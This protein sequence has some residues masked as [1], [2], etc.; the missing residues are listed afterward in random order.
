M[1][2]GEKGALVAYLDHSAHPFRLAV[3]VLVVGFA[4]VCS[5]VVIPLFFIH[6]SENFL[7]QLDRVTERVALLSGFYIF[8]DAVG[9]FL[10]L[11]RNI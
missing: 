1:I 9:L 8:L 6:R 4:A 10:I 5:S 3:L 7:R 2:D 11:Y